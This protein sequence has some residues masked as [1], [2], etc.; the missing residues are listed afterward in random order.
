VVITG[1]SGFLGR[2]LLEEMKE[3]YQIV[4]MARRSP[5]RTGAPLHRNITWY[6]V[7][8][9]DRRSLKQAFREVRR[10]GGAEIVI[11]LAAYYDFTGENHPDYTRTNVEGLRNVLDECQILGLRRFVFASSAAACDFKSGD[12]TIDEN[13]VPDA[14]HPYGTSKRLGEEMLREYENEFPSCI[15]R[16]AALFSDWCEYPPLFVFLNSWLST[17]WRRRILGGKGLFAV[18]LLHVREGV[19]VVRGAVEHCDDLP[20]GQVLLAGP[21]ITVPTRQLFE[22]ATLYQSGVAQKPLILPRRLCGLGMTLRD[23]L[24]GLLGERPFERTWMASYIDR[25]LKTDARRTRNLV[26]WEPRERL[27]I[28]RRLPFLIENR[29]SD[30]AEWYRRNHEAMRAVDTSAHLRVHRLLETHEH[31]IVERVSAFM[32]GDEG[33]RQF[34]SYQKLSPEDREWNHRVA[35]RH[36]MDAVRTRDKSIY[37]SFCRDLAELRHAQG[38]G[39]EEVGEA[40]L[41]LR[42]ISLRVL[43]EDPEAE[44]ISREIHDHIVMTMVFGCDQAQE[45]LEQLGEAEARRPCLSLENGRRERSE[46]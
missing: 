2:H 18:P 5:A 32:T 29:K 28:T 38:F 1:S 25:Q 22:D 4:G 10:L 20:P 45:A 21:E 26:G 3:D 13:S 43:L 30:P 40:L 46:L 36:L 33:R 16:F 34:P 9:R 44:E 12:R 15:I 11:H 37:S 14:R 41:S 23:R 6:Q 35:L 27:S 42:Y 24:R 8:I 17:S 31:E 19:K 7:D 39:M